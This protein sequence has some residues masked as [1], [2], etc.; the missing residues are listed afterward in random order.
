MIKNIYEITITH[1]D[2]TKETIATRAN[3][4]QEAVNRIRKEFPKADVII[5]RETKYDWT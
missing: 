4:T 1:E 2:L 5:V 3:T